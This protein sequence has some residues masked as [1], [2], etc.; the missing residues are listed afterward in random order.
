ML[1]INNLIDEARCYE[2][3]RKMR[4][5]NSIHCPHCT[6]NK[7]RKRGKNHRQQ[8]CRRYSCENCGRRLDD[9]T[10]RWDVVVDRGAPPPERRPILDEMKT[11]LLERSYVNNLLAAVE[12][13]AAEIT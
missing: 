1:R 10:A 3:I 5:K 9:L 13:E 6:S 8:E 12:K 11:L 2:E 4:W 7:I